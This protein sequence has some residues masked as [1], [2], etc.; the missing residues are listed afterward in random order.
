MYP[1]TS[2]SVTVANNLG[3]LPLK[4]SPIFFHLRQKSHDVLAKCFG[5]Q[6]SLCMK[7]LGT[8]P[9]GGCKLSRVP[10]VELS[11]PNVYNGPIDTE[12]LHDLS[13]SI[14]VSRT[15]LRPVL[16][17]LRTNQSFKQIRSRRPVVTYALSGAMNGPPGSDGGELFPT[18]PTE[19]IVG[20]PSNSIRTAEV[21]ASEKGDKE[22][23][24]SWEVFIETAIFNCRFFTLM[25]IM[26]SLAG[27]LLCFFKGSLYV[28]DSFRTYFHTCLYGVHTG[29]VIFYL[30]EAIDVYLVGTVM[31]IFGMGLHGLFISNQP[32]EGAGNSKA[33]LNS[34]LFGMFKLTERPQWMKINSLDVMKTKLGHVIVMILLVGMFEKSKKIPIATSLDLVGFAIAIALSSWSILILHQLHH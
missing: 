16:C 5:V 24:D 6:M 15:F 34:S 27:A 10:S 18:S 22:K 2:A 13:T 11:K 25:A 20:D 4:S 33:F 29:K 3:C 32:T 14:G 30:I 21:L 23:M 19:V 28:V 12:I 8:H 31:L 1:Q 17:A 26:G 9:A 7:S